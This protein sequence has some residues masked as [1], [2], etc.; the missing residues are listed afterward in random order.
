MKKPLT[1]LMLTLWAG[2]AMARGETGEESALN[3]V[4]MRRA[5]LT[6]S[7]DGRWRLHVGADKV[8]HRVPLNGT[9]PEQQFTLPKPALVLSAS[10][11]GQRVAFTVGSGCVGLVDFGSGPAAAAAL[12][13][14]PNQPVPSGVRR[15]CDD[16]SAAQLGRQPIALSPDG[17]W[18]A[19]PWHVIDTETSQTIATLPPTQ[20]DIGA[21]H[22]VHLQ[23]VDNGRKL[24]V[25]TA[26]LGEGYESASSPSNLQF[27]V[28]DMGDKSLHR[29]LSL[30][31]DTLFFPQG[32]FFSHSTA[33]GALYWVDSRAYVAARQDG[34]PEDEL[35]RLQL[36]QSWLTGC[37]AAVAPRFKLPA[38]AW[39][40]MLVDPQGRW[41]AATRPLS[42]DAGAGRGSSGFTEELVV[43]D[44]DSARPIVQRALQRPMLGLVALPDGSALLG[45][46]P[47]PPDP[48]TGLPLTGQ[49]GGELIRVDID[50]AQLRTAKLAP[51]PWEGACPLED[52]VAGARQVQAQARP[53]RLLWSIEGVKSLQDLWMQAA[54]PNSSGNA[55]CEMSAERL[56]FQMKD[57]TLWLDRY[58]DIAQLDPASGR[59]LRTLPTPRRSDV[60]SVVVPEANGFVNHQGDT[61]SWRPFEGSAPRRLLEQFPGWRV[62]RVQRDEAGRIHSTWTPKPGTQPPTAKDD[63]VLDMRLLAHDPMSFKRLADTPSDAMTTDFIGY[64]AL[65][66][67][68]ACELAPG[69]PARPFD[70]QLSHFDSFRGYAC[71]GSARRTVF[72]S[73]LDIAPRAAQDPMIDAPRRAWTTAAGLAVA[74]DG[75]VLRVFELAA[76]R[77]LGRVVLEAES[78]LDVQ[79]LPARAQLLLHLSER[80]ADGNRREV[81]RMYGFR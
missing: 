67:P 13:W 61:L 6:L 44:I 25:V 32:F 71:E 30:D 31:D 45:L 11:S 5:P 17:R 42:T 62:Y 10:R 18:L 79:L 54:D 40:S 22:P 48:Q 70:W 34:R 57:G 63:V 26:T 75:H 20:Q 16:G 69:L 2:V 43:F 19:T 1:L 21:R 46:T 55:A 35:P 49:G 33:T 27:A 74:Q 53:A 23:F 52:E 9:Q 50:V 29:L 77:E 66:Q 73:H 12:T 56:A 72:W 81:V 65:P 78:V 76:R 60:C 58:V 38:W 8:L 28:W 80:D 4:E 39:H 14:W 24:F 59:I 15:G 7:A 37:K 51:V 64:L 36:M 47:L 41:V 68:A 3:E